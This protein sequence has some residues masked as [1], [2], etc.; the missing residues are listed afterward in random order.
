[1]G[2]VLSVL[3]IT[4][5]YNNWTIQCVS[6]KGVL[7]EL[8]EL[9]FGVPQGSVLGPVEFCINTIPLGAIFKHYKRNYHIYADDT[10]IYCTFEI[11]SLDEIL[12]LI[13]ECIADIRYWMMTNKLKIN[14]DETKLLLITSPSAK[15]TRDIQI[16]IGKDQY[17]IHLLARVLGTCYL[18]EL[19][20]KASAVLLTST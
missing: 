7:S 12:V 18:W 11:N 2:N 14:D 3:L 16:S 9:A 10:Q 8:R 20:L 5:Y 6:I 15:L 19:R 13:C 1:M 4:N 17:H